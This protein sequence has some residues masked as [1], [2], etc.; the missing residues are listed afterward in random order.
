[1]GVRDISNGSHL[2]FFSRM[3]A[4]CGPTLGPAK[5]VCGGSVFKLSDAVIEQLATGTDA[6]L[7]D[8][9]SAGGHLYAVGNNGPFLTSTGGP[10]TRVELPTKRK[11]FGIYATADAVYIVGKAGTIIKSTPNGSSAPISSGTDIYGPSALSVARSLPSVDKAPLS[12]RIMED[13][14]RA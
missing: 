4:V 12:C 13:R 2:K 6:F 11:L 3:A 1:M 7:Y 8:M 10:F 9:T 5:Y 14:L